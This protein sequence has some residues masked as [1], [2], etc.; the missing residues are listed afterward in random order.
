MAFDSIGILYH[1]YQY[2]DIAY[3]GGGFG[4]GIHNTLEAATF[5]LPI[6]FGPNYQKFNEAKDLI[7]IGAAFPIKNSSDFNTIFSK[8]NTDTTYREE[9]GKKAKDFILQQKGGTKIIL[10][11]I[12]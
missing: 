1:L 11:K 10:E 9:T 12:I 7:S 6:I 5:G 4:V 3:I 8:L 2:A